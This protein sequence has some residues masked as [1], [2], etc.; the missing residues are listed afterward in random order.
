MQKLRPDDL[1]L[2]TMLHKVEQAKHTPDWQK[3]RGQYIPYP[4][5]WL[6]G[7]GWDDEYVFAV[8]V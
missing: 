3:E 1:I 5:T 6:N 7:K 4:A 8:S 2:G